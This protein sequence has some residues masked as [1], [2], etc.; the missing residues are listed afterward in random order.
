[1]RDESIDREEISRVDHQEPLI[2]KPLEAGNEGVMPNK[3]DA[4]F[5]GFIF[6]DV[7]H[8]R[9]SLFFEAS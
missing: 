3:L 4:A 6:D 5:V 9:R 7:H 8:L 2:I 1:M